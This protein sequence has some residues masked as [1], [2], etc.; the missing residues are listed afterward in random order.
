MRVPC[1]IKAEMNPFSKSS[2]RIAVSRVVLVI[3]VLVVFIGA[4]VGA[5]YFVG[6][7]S[8]KQIKVVQVEIR[9]IPSS[10]YFYPRNVTVVIG[11]NN[12]VTWTNEDPTFT[13]TVTQGTPVPVPAGATA[14][15]S[16]EYPTALNCPST[17]SLFDS[18]NLKYN[19]TFT[20]TLPSPGVYEYFSV[21][22][23]NDGNDAIGFVLVKQ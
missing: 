11:V 5:L 16:Q 21:Y 17:I 13:N 15:C 10:Q 2:T 1:P 6:G 9:P 8:P 19:E 22:H 4:A 14:S 3:V 7:L 18:G 12:T 23:S 20:F